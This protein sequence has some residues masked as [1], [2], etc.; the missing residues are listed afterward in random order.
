MK[1]VLVTGT[2]DFLHPGHL[3][4]FRRA[5]RYG[6]YLTVVVA[7]DQTAKKVKG[8]LP[9]HNERE[10]LSMVKNMDLVDAAVLGKAGDKLAVVEKIRPDIICLGYDQRAFTENLRA[11]LLKRG[12]RIHVMRL[13]AYRPQKYKSSIFRSASLIDLHTLDRTLAIDLPYAAKRNFTKKKLYRHQRAFLRYDVAKR[14][15]QAHKLLKRR[16]YR[17]K[18]W[19]AYRPLSVQKILWKHKPDPRY[20]VPPRIGSPHNRGAAIDC[21]LADRRGK[22]LEM[23]TAYDEFSV[24][25]HR[26]SKHMT[27]KQRRNMF[28]LEHAMRKAGFLP[29][30]TEWWHFSAPNWKR[31]PILDIPL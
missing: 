15:L 21:T 16:G 22:E 8:R 19:D 26:I 23:P 7:R 10:R 31:L 2:F 14:L 27:A 9:Y 18:I 25:A 6:N 4:F 11:E 1:T 17:L 29:L 12:L 5:K 24:K 3:W 28:I 13:A 20:V 30:P